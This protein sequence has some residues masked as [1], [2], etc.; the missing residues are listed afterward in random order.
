MDKI[1]SS[2]FIGIIDVFF[3]MI[4]CFL[5]LLATMLIQGGVIVGGSGAGMQYVFDI[6]K[7]AMVV[8]WM[9]A[10]IVFIIKNSNKEL[11]SMISGIY[12]NN[13]ETTLRVKQAQPKS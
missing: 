4:L 12:D 5:T 8:C 13:A 10:Y 6:S 1:R 3:I 7:F 11:K 9:V 2:R